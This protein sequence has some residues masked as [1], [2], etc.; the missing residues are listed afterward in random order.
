VQWFDDRFYLVW[1]VELRTYLSLIEDIILTNRFTAQD[2]RELGR[3]RTEKSK[4]DDSIKAS[5]RIGIFCGELLEKGIEIKRDE[6]K[7]KIHELGLKLP[8]TTIDKIWKA[9]PEKYRKKA[10]APQK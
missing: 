9:I 1:T 8:N 5:V 7:D 4:W 6:L 3:L 10:G 2:A